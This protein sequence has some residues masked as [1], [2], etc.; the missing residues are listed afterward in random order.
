MITK[1]EVKHCGRSKKFDTEEK[2]MQFGIA[3]EKLGYSVKVYMLTISLYSE[4]KVQ[5]YQTNKIK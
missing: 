1:Y 3:L 2:A 5:I 4:L